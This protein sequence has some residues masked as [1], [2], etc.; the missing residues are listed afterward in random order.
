MICKR[1]GLPVISWRDGWK[2]ASGGKLGKTP[3]SRKH[4]PEPVEAPAD[5]ST[6]IIAMLKA[7]KG[8]AK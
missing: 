4:K 5:D 8:G 6:S 7:R 3:P 2:H 1:C